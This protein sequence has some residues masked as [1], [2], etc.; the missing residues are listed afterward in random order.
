MT[1]STLAF[2]I[3]KRTAPTPG[4]QRI[5]VWCF[6][7]GD[8]PSLPEIQCSTL[9]RIPFMMKRHVLLKNYKLEKP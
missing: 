4:H 1:P 8:L 7:D 6:V 2:R 3:W 9:E 5:H